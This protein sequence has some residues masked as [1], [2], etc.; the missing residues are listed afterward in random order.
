MGKL[1]AEEPVKWICLWMENNWNS[2][3]IVIDSIIEGIDG[4]I[5]MDVIDLMEWGGAINNCDILG[6]SVCCEFATKE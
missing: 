1:I 3:L 4:V 2:K 5:K 6:S